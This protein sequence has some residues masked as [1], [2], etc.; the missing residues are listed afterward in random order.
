M[1]FIVSQ[2]DCLTVKFIK[3]YPTAVPFYLIFHWFFQIRSQMLLYGTGFQASFTAKGVLSI[4]FAFVALKSSIIS[5]TLSTTL[6]FIGFFSGANSLM[7]FDVCRKCKV[8]VTILT[9]IRLLSSVGL[10]VLFQ[11]MCFAKHFTTL[12]ASKRFLP[13]LNHHVL[14]EMT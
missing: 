6:A 11:P 3:T 8:L 4:V 1:V 2:K 12:H 10:T 5:K 9:L 13:C 7:H 14:F